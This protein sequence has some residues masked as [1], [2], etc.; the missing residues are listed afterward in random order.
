MLPFDR[1]AVCVCVLPVFLCRHRLI[2]SGL[3]GT[4]TSK[5]V[6][7]VQGQR[8]EVLGKASTRVQQL[9]NALAFDSRTTVCLT[10]VLV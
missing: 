2:L 9:V 10:L 7:G 3:V 4:L 8:F 1:G 6:K 5:R